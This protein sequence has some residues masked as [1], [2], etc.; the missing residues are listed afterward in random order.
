MDVFARVCEALRQ[1]EMRR[2]RTYLDQ[3]SHS[4]RFTTWLVAVVRNITIDWFRSRD[5]RRRLSTIADNMPAL[6]KQI[7]EEIFVEGRSHLE[8]YERICAISS[9]PPAFR[10]FLVELRETYKA[11]SAGRRGTILRD[12]APIDLAPDG[13]DLTD[14]A[15]SDERSRRVEEALRTLPPQDR[16]AVE[17]YVLEE[18]SAVEIARIMGLRNAKAAYNRVYRALDVLRRHMAAQGLTRGDL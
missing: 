17:L 6:R 16:A 12:L 15:V 7:F 2:V 14:P 8:A 10:E 11:A 3:P 1:D 9:K 4:A 5:G 18:L 13:L